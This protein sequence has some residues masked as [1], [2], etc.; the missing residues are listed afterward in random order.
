MSNQTVAID[1]SVRRISPQQLAQQGWRAHQTVGGRTYVWLHRLGWILQ[2]CGHPTAN[3]P[4]ELRDP[5]GHVVLTGAAAGDPMTGRAWPT[6]AS[7][8]QYVAGCL[9]ASAEHEGQQLS[10]RWR[11]SLGNISARSGRMER[12]SPLFGGSGENPTLF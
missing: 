8:A 10:Q 11:E 5:S 7:A 2:H 6:L 4:W 12:E 3:Y 1:F 9:A